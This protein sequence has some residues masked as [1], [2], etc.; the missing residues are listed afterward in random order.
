MLTMISFNVTECCQTVPRF[1]DTTMCDFLVSLWVGLGEGCSSVL[2]LTFFVKTYSLLF[3][4]N[5]VLLLHL[6]YVVVF[7]I[8]EGGHTFGSCQFLS[9]PVD[10]LSGRSKNFCI[11]YVCRSYHSSSVCH[12][13]LPIK[14]Q[15]SVRDTTY[16]DS[17]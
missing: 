17:W 16:S 6:F 4:M 9:V 5:E 7:L 2:H 11:N 3:K 12:D 10:T 14:D 1:T 8:S 15:I 13:P